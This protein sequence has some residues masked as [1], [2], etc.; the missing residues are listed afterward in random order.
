MISASSLNLAFMTGM[1]MCIV[2]MLFAA[3]AMHTTFI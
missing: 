3:W 2:T 1:T